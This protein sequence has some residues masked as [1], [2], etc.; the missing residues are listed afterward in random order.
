MPL[1]DCYYSQS[2]KSDTNRLSKRKRVRGTTENVIVWNISNRDP[3]DIAFETTSLLGEM[4]NANAT[5]VRD[6]NKLFY[7]YKE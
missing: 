4:A 2:R 5:I 7:L 3:R 1:G 6:V